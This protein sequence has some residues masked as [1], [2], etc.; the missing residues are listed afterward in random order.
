MKRVF[1]DTNI[2]LRFL[3]KDVPSQAKSAKELLTKI[4]NGKISGFTSI[5]VVV[6]IIWVLDSFY[7]FPKKQIIIAIRSLIELP[8]LEIEEARLI[9]EALSVWEHTKA[10]FIDC[11]NYLKACREDIYH[12]ASFDIDWDTFDNVKR[13]KS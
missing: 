2:F 13:L 8:N 12:I 5:L 6:E 4:K 9:R 1:V 11:Y 3:L 7:N 10:G